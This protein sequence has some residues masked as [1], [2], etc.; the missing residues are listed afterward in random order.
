MGGPRRVWLLLVCAVSATGGCAHFDK[1]VPV[2]PNV[3][4]ERQKSLLGEYVIESPRVPPIRSGGR[5]RSLM[6]ITLLPGGMSTLS[7]SAIS[8]RGAGMGGA[9]SF[10]PVHTGFLPPAPSNDAPG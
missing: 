10:H 9:A 8:G 3:P 2:I 6:V 4:N 5:C 7:S 1:S